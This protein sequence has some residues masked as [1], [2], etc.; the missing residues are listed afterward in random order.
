MSVIRLKGT[1]VST[2]SKSEV[3]PDDERVEEEDEERIPEPDGEFEGGEQESLLALT[4]SL[5]SFHVRF[6]CEGR[7]T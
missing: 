7:L 6:D 5:I 2:S 3:L 4:I 1:S